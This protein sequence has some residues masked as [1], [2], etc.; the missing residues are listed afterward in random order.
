MEPP[1]REGMTLD[2]EVFL[3][4]LSL[5]VLPKGFIKIRHYGILSNRNRK[6]KIPFFA[7]FSVSWSRSAAFLPTGAM[8]ELHEAFVL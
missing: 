7:V 8:P 1:K 3:R 2:V 5:H 4:R 6:E